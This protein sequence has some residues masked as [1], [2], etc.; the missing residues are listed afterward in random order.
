MRDTALRDEIVENA[1]KMVSEKYD[2]NIVA[3]D[4][5]EKIFDTL[6]A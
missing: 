4:M 6:F 1:F 2:W 5:K 3:K